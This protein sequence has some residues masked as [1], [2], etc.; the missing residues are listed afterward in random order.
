MIAGLIACTAVPEV[1]ADARVVYDEGTAWFPS[2]QY[3]HVEMANYLDPR[4]HGDLGDGEAM[5]E[6]VAVANVG[7]LGDEQYT[8]AALLM[9]S[10]LRFA[11]YGER[12][13]KLS[14]FSWPRVKKGF[15]DME[16]RYPDSKANLNYFAF[17]AAIAGDRPTARGLFQLIGDDYR[18]AVWGNRNYYERWRSWARREP[19]DFSLA[20][21]SSLPAES[22]PVYLKP[23]QS[24]TVQP[25]YSSQSRDTANVMK[26]AM[27]ARRE[28]LLNRRR[29]MLEQ[30]RQRMEDYK[31]E[32]MS[33]SRRHQ[34]EEQ[35]RRRK[36]TAVPDSRVNAAP[37][38]DD[39]DGF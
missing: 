36:E 1:P 25:V 37:K 11:P 7:D 17:F 27:K 9:H 18:P 34:I 15:L 8:R 28:Q 13:F 35:M 23:G 20:F 33:E 39:S 10:D 24:I 31:H 26:N 32:Q 30:Q 3:L 12:F 29:Q 21:G 14:D 5:L 38:S 19:P 16:K 4:W 6:K 22:S 2:Y